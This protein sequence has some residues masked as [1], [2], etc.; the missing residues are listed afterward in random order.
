MKIL[1]IETSCD[2]TALAIIEATGTQLAPAF[3][4]LGTALFSQIDIHR[5][6]G[7]VFPA[8][9]KREHA[10]RFVPLLSELLATC[11]QQE[12]VPFDASNVDWENIETLLAREPALFAKLKA[13][14]ETHEKPLIDMI[15]V[16]SGPGLEPAL[17]VGINAARALSLIWNIP[18][19]PIN[20]MEGHIVSVLLEAQAQTFPMLALLISGGH[21]EL[22]SIESWGH[23]TKI[24]MTRD[25]AIGEAYDKVARMM[26][27]PYPGG[28]EIA[29][30]AE[31]ARTNNVQ[32]ETIALPRPMINTNDFDFSLSGLKTAVLYKV[33][34]LEKIAPL[35]ELQM[36]ALAREFEQAVTDVIVAKTTRA[37][38]AT[39][40]HA[41]IVGG[42]V[43]ANTYI[44]SALQN[45]GTSLDLP[46]FFPTQALSTDNAIMIAIAGYVSQFDRTPSIAP[47]IRAQG[48]LSL[49][50]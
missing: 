42:G 27:L 29:R 14:V 33:Q 37:L 25:D 31:V 15:A 45:I 44:R 22:V 2:E 48:N 24:G 28:P 50:R 9:A 13:Y 43:I 4:V 34:A 46:V 23:Y 7:G 6:F 11:K 41:L 49:E 40:A 47:E 26:G 1:G 16:T 20:H 39:R 32:D 38:E 36:Q 18:M 5:A 17:W 19:L 35:T 3:T 10:E 12:T 8:V 21:T 30:L